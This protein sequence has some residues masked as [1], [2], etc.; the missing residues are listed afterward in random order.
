MADVVSKSFEYRDEIV[1][2][3]KITRKA[4]ARSSGGR[5]VYE[6]KGLD[7]EWRLAALVPE[8]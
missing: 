1:E 5:G 3:P 8:R 2:V 7:G 6:V 4:H